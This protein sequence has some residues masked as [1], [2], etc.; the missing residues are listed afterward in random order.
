L[1]NNFVPDFNGQIFEP[2]TTGQG[3]FPDALGDSTGPGPIQSFFQRN[4][5]RNL[6]GL[7]PQAQRKKKLT[8]K[9]KKKAKK[10]F[11]KG[12]K[13]ALKLSIVFG[14]PALIVY[15]SFSTGLNL[16]GGG[17]GDGNKR[18]LGGR[19]S[20]FTFLHYLFGFQPQAQRRKKLTDKFKKKAKKTLKKGLKKALK[21]SILFGIPA[22]IVYSSVSTGLFLGGGGGGGGGGDGGGGGAG[23]GGGGGGGGTGRRR[24]RS[25]GRGG[26]GG[27]NEGGGG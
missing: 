19:D 4:S 9:F 12:L 13:K 25:G 22:L 2:G 17:G 21:L 3:I 27:G 6:F 18:S 16:G 5:L 20:S 26:R 7:Q 8:D 14:I 1:A 24:R 11:K 15:S 23:G 10:I